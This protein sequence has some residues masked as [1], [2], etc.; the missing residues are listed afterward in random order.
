MAFLYMSTTYFLEQFDTTRK[1]DWH[2]ILLSLTCCLVGVSRNYK[3]HNISHRILYIFCLFGG[4]G[5]NIIL[6]SFILKITA[7]PIFNTQ[8]KSV[9][10]IVD[11]KF[12]LVGDRFA[13]QHMMKKNE[14]PI[15]FYKFWLLASI[16]FK[17]F[18][19]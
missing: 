4:M 13:L 7:N 16:L 9:H 15:V 1:S 12:D 6:C 18:N 17:H 2:T 10:E 3:A 8:I 11:G 14:V 5:F 19:V